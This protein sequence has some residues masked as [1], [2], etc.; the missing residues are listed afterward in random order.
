MSFETSRRRML[1]SRGRIMT[2]KRQITPSSEISH[3]LLGFL[4]TY[5]AEQVSGDVRQGDATVATM[6]DE[7]AAAAWVPP[8]RV[9][10]ILVIGGR[11]W[12]VQGSKPIYDG[13]TLIGWEFWVRGG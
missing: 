1:A 7:I 9:R 8:P 13:E 3:P 10:D 4:Q 5:R 11:T 2:L 6:H 12:A